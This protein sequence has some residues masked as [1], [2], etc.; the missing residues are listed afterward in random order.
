MRMADEF[1]RGVWRGALVVCGV[2]LAAA[3]VAGCGGG[4]QA[5]A[6]ARIVYEARAE[7][8]SVNIFTILPDGKSTKQLTQ[9]TGFSGHPGWSP[10]HGRIVFASDRDSDERRYDIYTMKADGGDV[11]RLTET[12]AWSE[13]APKYSND[14][15]QVV[16][17]R[18]RPEGSFIALMGADG[19]GQLEIAGPYKFAEFPAWTRDGTQV[20]F[21]A[22]EQGRD[23][24]DVYSVDLRT[25]Q[26]R[27]R[28][29]TPAADVCP[30]FSRDGKTLTYASVAPGDENA[31][32]MDLF[33]HDLTGPDQRTNPDDTRLTDAP[34]IDDY[35]NTSADDTTFVF[36]SNR[37]G[38]TELYLMDRDG[39]HQRRLTHTPDVNEN[40]P[41]W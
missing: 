17:V 4:K 37:D 18:V 19:S 3:A 41:D 24:I 36:L 8:K 28:I 35:A 16:Y 26:V 15:T 9:G 27:T 13:W 25:K 6:G 10:D 31:G 39:G 2:A 22:I 12:P 5:E 20:F 29:S 40:V 34:G 11:R 23:D 14:G 30:H 1:G 7:D 21:A 32:N 38:N 33:A